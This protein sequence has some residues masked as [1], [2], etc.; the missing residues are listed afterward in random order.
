M[1][2]PEF[3]ALMMATERV[4]PGAA[5]RVCAHEET[6]MSKNGSRELTPADARVLEPDVLGVLALLLHGRNEPAE[7][8]PAP[9]RPP[10]GWRGLGRSRSLK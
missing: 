8:K 9:P 4:E 5:F 10:A 7:P 6:A 3:S 2:F 1:E